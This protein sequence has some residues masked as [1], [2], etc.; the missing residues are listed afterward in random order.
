MKIKT[1]KN[2]FSQ[3]PKSKF[4]NNWPTSLYMFNHPQLHLITAPR[5]TGKT[6][7]MSKIVLAGINEK[8]YDRIFLISPTAQ[9]NL[10][11]LQDLNIQEEDIFL[12]DVDAIQNV[13]DEVEA[14]RDEYQKYLDEMK[15]Y[16]DIIN[17]NTNNFTDEEFELIEDFIIEDKLTAP[18]YKRPNPRRPQCIV[19]LDDILS[20]PVMSQG[21]SF[22]RLMTINR[23]IAPMRDG[24]ACGLGLIILAQT[25]STT[26]GHGLSRGLRENLTELTIFQNKQDKMLDKMISEFGGAISEE[27][28]RQAYDIAIREPFD[29]L[30][31]SFGRLACETLRF[32]KDL[33]NFIIFPEAEKECHCQ[34]NKKN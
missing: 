20:T 25:Y 30:T 16:Q 27:Q 19:I 18:K 28:F 10:K 17:N 1:V 24:G 2:I 21:S 22:N 6:H 13:M 14:E 9:S 33:N 8:L 5:G 32:R 31:I 7:L 34:K 15:I 3:S 26:N 4:D 23:H 12:P 11:Q 29:N